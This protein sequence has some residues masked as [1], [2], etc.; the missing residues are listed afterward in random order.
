VELDQSQRDKVPFSGTSA[1]ISLE[2]AAC[3]VVPGETAR[4]PFTLRTEQEAQSIHDLGVVS[5][6]P[7][8]NR[9]WTHIVGSSDGPAFLRRYIL[10]IRPTDIR[11]HQYGTYPLLITWGTPGTHRYVD[12][13]CVLV[14]RPCV[15]LKAQP[16]IAIRPTGELSL[17]IENCG[18]LD[19]DVS[20]TLS[21]HGSS[22]SKGWEFELGTEDGPFE[23]SEQFDLPPDARKPEFDLGISAEGI[24]LVQMKVR[25]RRLFSSRKHMTTAAVALA[26]AA[27]AVAATFA[28]IGMGTAL[29]PQKITFTSVV[30]TAPVPGDTH[31]VT[32]TGGRSG[33]PVT[34]SID[35]SSTSVCSVSGS[36][37]TFNQAGSCVIDAN[38]AGNAK[39]QAAPQAQQT[40]TVTGGTSSGGS[41]SSGSS[42]TGG[43]SGGT[44]S[45]GSSSGGSSSGGSSSG[46]GPLGQNITFTSLPPANPVPGDTYVVTVTGGGSG[47]P[48]T[49]S[50]DPS[51]TSVCSV[52]GSTVTFNQAGSCVIDANQ[53]G[54]A[55]YQA[56]PQA[57]QTV[58]VTSPIA[59]TITFTSSPH[60]P[61]F[62]GNTYVVTATG[63][64][65]GNPVTYSID[66]SSTWVC[67]VSGA[68]VTIGTNAPNQGGTCVIDA[69]QAGGG[70]YQAASQAQQTLTVRSI[71]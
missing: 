38:Q 31:V 19:I 28:L 65:S 45:G 60:G 68:T 36:T 16:A 59:Q 56:A 49:Y 27:I 66:P 18:L 43:S 2:R 24:P 48:V 26:A 71:D 5:A 8:F 32:A 53:A 69:N 7:H 63:G 37:V 61:Y 23:F 58:T 62:P 34:Y 25:P 57:Q 67:S 4:F 11:R 33:N 55:K 35:P 3:R 1:D 52:S 14:I 50:I 44:S 54:N 13:Q 20:V 17:S 9:E 12:S 30:S 64:G 46:R 41:S 29:H 22:W 47:N 21:H 51:S 70:K 39:Y 10:E 42:S 15:R 6:N 40:V